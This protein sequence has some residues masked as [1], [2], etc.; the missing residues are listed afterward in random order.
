M[1]EEEREEMTPEEAPE[2]SASQ[3]HG[4]PSPESQ[5]EAYYLEHEASPVMGALA[6]GMPWLISLLFHL[7]LFLIMMFVVFVVLEPKETLDIIIPDANLSENPGGRM[8]Q[9][10]MQRVTRSKTATKVLKEV[11]RDESVS[12]SDT[13]SKSLAISGISGPSSPRMSLSNAASQNLPKSQFFGTGGNAYNIC[14]VI[15]RSG[16]MSDTFDFVRIEMARSIG[17]LKEKQAFHVIMF[18]E[19][20]PIEKDPPKL[21]FATRDNQI[22]AAEF[23]ASI[24]AEG[25]TDP[26]PALERAFEVLKNAKFKG[27][28]IYLL[29]DGN[30]PDNEKVL[31]AIQKMNHSGNVFINTFLYG[32]G[33]PQAQ[34]VMDQ[35]ASQ[36]GGKFRMV[37]N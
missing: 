14:W 1:T 5:D 31:A 2:S 10:T 35:I 34:K 27:K 13:T 19:G 6:S 3:T 9:Q 22:K 25:Q 8:T 37:G 30:F 23:I 7:G 36:N 15:D 18:A 28:L 11:Q 33:D 32:S 16:S 29:T 4:D 24:N 26:I 12:V 17:R 20:K 21:V